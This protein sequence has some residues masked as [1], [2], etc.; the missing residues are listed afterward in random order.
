MNIIPIIFIFICGF[1]FGLVLFILLEK[2]AVPEV[3]LDI[4]DL[5]MV[6]ERKIK[7][8]ESKVSNPRIYTKPN[9]IGNTLKVA[10]TYNNTKEK[11]SL[12]NLETK[13]L[14][15]KKRNKIAL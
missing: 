15:L 9:L 1:S 7:A 12:T 10:Y 6:R 4:N 11:S 8:A 3:D 5:N 14:E 13:V 2:I